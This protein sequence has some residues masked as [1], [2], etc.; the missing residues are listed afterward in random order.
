MLFQAS[1]PSSCHFLLVLICLAHPYDLLKH[2]PESKTL[3]S[4]SKGIGSDFVAGLATVAKE[5]VAKLNR[6]NNKGWIFS[7]H[8]RRN[9]V[10]AT[11]PETPRP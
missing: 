1:P 3:L 7:R 5:G 11:V 6:I 8:F 4:P 2:D 10:V 9:V